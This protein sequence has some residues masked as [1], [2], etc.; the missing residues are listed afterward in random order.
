M[1]SSAKNNFAT[2][3]Y[4]ARIGAGASQES[5]TGRTYISALE[6]GLK[7]PTV[8][9]VDELAAALE[10]HPLTLLT[11]SYL[12]HETE[13]ELD[14]LLRTVREEVLGSLARAVEARRRPKGV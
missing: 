13:D 1:S 5:L 11:L 6:R 3:L 2:G 10:I 9:K 8:A 12:Q 14:T 4:V 7:Q